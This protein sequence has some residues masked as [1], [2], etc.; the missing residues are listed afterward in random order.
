METLNI[1]SD[2]LSTLIICIKLIVEV[3]EIL[4]KKHKKKKN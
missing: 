4:I 1:I 3:K 2:L